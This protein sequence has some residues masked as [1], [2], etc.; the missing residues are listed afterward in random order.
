MEPQ[1]KQITTDNLG[2]LRVGERVFSQKEH[3]NVIHNQ[4]LLGNKITYTVLVV[5][6]YLRKH[7]YVFACGFK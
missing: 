7:T 1:H 4:V 6:I 3:P 5:W 2:I